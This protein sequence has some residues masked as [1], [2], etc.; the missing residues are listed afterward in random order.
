LSTFFRGEVL[1]KTIAIF[2]SYTIT[3]LRAFNKGLSGLD[4]VASNGWIIGE[5]KLEMTWKEAVVLQ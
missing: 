3:P 1:E 4:Y 2:L 5:K